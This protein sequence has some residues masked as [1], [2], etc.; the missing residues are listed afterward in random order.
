MVIR[1]DPRC[2]DGSIADASGR[3]DQRIPGRNRGWH[4]L[5]STADARTLINRII[6][7]TLVG[8]TKREPDPAKAPK[9]DATTANALFNG[10]KCWLAA[11]DHVLERRVLQLEGEMKTLVEYL[12]RRGAA[13]GQEGRA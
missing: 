4:Y 9:L 13:P 5:R 3:V 11:H 10:V 7:L 2:G 8:D 12:E 6:N 1:T